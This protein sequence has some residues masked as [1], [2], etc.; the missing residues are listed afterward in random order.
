MIGNI[1]GGDITLSIDGVE[2]GKAQSLRIYRT[3]AYELPLPVRHM[4]SQK[5][6]R[7]R[8][9][10]YWRSQQRKPIGGGTYENAYYWI[11]AVEE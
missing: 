8:N 5:W 7:R 2:I 3:P 9:K 11:R 6:F 1:S 4:K 10:A